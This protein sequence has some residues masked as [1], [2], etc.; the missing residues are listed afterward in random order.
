MNSEFSA[1][2]RYAQ[3]IQ[4]AILPTAEVINALFKDNFVIFRPKESI[5][6]DFYYVKE[7]GN[8]II[9]MCGDCTGHGIPAALL[10]VLCHEIV[11]SNSRKYNDLRLII[12]KL[13]K[14]IIKNLTKVGKKDRVNDGLDIVPNSAN[15]F[16]S[17]SYFS[18]SLS[19]L[20]SFRVFKVLI[21]SPNGWL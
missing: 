21:G 19:F 20:K 13:N 14:S 4:Q 11:N 12:T 8:E 2:L 1:S 3:N 15:S 5:G 16:F 18:V 17:L 10:S 6:G 9:F 7:V